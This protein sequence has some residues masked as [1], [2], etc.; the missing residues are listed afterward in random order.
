[1]LTLKAYRKHFGNAS[2][3]LI[4]FVPPTESG[5]LVRH[6][7]E[8]VASVLKIPISDRLKKN[9]HTEAQKLLHSAITKKDNVHGKF[10]YES[11]EEIVGK[12]ILL[13]D[14]IFDSGCTVKEIGLYLT[15]LGAE[16][17]APLV[18]A[19]TVGGDLD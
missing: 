10:S 2:F 13:I 12:K 18:I 8:K 19:R 3:D 6:F 11:A 7:A 16:V 17:I 5:D 15:G 4:L 9:T 14:D 1:V